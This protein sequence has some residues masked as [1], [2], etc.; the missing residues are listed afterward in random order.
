MVEIAVIL[1]ATPLLQ[2]HLAG[3]S[4]RRVLKLKS[5]KTGDDFVCGASEL[6]ASYRLGPRLVNAVYQPQSQSVGYETGF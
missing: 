5:R 1:E 4:R 2:V 3:E 6:C